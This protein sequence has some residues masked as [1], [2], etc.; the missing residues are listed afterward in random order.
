M[1]DWVDYIRSQCMEHD[2]MQAAVRKKGKSIKG[3]IG[4]LLEWSFNNQIPVDKDILKAAK[5]SAGR[6][7]AL[8]SLEWEK[9]KKIIKKYYTE[10]K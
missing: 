2:D 8:E 4:K 7:N 6:V 9:S 3:C 10:A 1:T 5:V